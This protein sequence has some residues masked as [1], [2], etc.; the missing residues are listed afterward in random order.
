MTGP[1]HAAGD[2]PAASTLRLMRISE[3]GDAMWDR[4]HASPRRVAGLVLI[5]NGILVAGDSGEAAP[6]LWL[7]QFDAQGRA[8]RESRLPAA[9]G[10]RAAALA[11]LGNGR[12]VIVGTAALETA[13]QRGAGFIFLDHDRQLAAGR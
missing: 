4:R 1:K 7:A 2:A 13:A 8:V 12:L 5:K 11:E 9:K 3:D 10:D 6:E